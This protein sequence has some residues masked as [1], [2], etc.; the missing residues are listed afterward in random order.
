MG[1]ALLALIIKH[2]LVVIVS[3]HARPLGRALRGLMVDGSCGLHVSI[4]AR[5]LGRALPAIGADF[6]QL[7]CFNPRPPFG[8]GASGS[9]KR[10]QFPTCLVRT[11]ANPLFPQGEKQHRRVQYDP[12]A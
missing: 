12:T 2:L 10:G 1:R 3:I 6:R 4:H 7:S 5:P 9:L 8:T 11:D